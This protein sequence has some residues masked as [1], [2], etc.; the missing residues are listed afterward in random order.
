MSIINKVASVPS[1]QHFGAAVASWAAQEGL[2]MPVSEQVV[3]CLDQVWRHGLGSSVCLP[4]GL[5]FLDGGSV[6]LHSGFP[7]TKSRSKA[8]LCKHLSIQSCP[9]CIAEV[10]GLTLHS[11]H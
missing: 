2:Q 10:L 1:L 3:P 11:L 5:C 8:D 7:F 4:P 9:V 6:P